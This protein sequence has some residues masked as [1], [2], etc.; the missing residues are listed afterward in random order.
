MKKNIA[1]FAFVLG[2]ARPVRPGRHRSGP[3]RRRGGST[4]SRAC[5]AVR[6]AAAGVAPA[7]GTPQATGGGDS[8]TKRI[9][10]LALVIGAAAA[11]AAP[12]APAHAEACNATFVREC[13]QDVVDALSAVREPICVTTFDVCV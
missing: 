5:P 1:R 7:A 8:M 11:L 4:P 2:A 9:T 13:V 6:V 3:R 12:A 10:R